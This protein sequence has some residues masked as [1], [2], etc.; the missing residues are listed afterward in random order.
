[1]MIAATIQ[2]FY[3]KYRSKGLLVD[4]NLLLVYFI[5]L[6]DRKLLA[7]FERTRAFDEESFLLLANFIRSFKKVVTTPNILTEV[8]NLSNKL[9]GNTRLAYFQSLIEQVG[10]TEEY[11]L[12]SSEL[13][14]HPSFEKFGLTDISVINVSKDEYLV[15]TDDF[16]LSNY[17]TK[18]G[19]AAINFNHLRQILWDTEQKSTDLS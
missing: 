15:L 11:Y 2:D 9:K 3:N 16:P 8:S 6:C 18:Q 13:S 17:L 4:S 14:Q 5:G 10:L 12:R 1:M 7:K 19:Q